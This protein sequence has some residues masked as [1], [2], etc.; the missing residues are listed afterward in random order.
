MREK[1]VVD[2][3]DDKNANFLSSNSISW[4]KIIVTPGGGAGKIYISTTKDPKGIGTVWKTVCKIP[5][6]M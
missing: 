5:S 2:E 3:E 4:N 1:C 6:G